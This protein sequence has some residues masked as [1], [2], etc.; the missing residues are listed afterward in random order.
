M[1]DICSLRD[2]THSSPAYHEIYTSERERIF[3]RVTINELKGKGID[4]LTDSMLVDVRSVRK[5]TD[6]VHQTICATFEKLYD[7]HFIT[8][9]KPLILSIEQCH[10]L[11]KLDNVAA[12][13]VSMTSTPQD[14]TII[15]SYK[16]LPSEESAYWTE[17]CYFDVSR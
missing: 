3:T 12:W 1:P 11:R 7:H 5:T 13:N 6:A 10:T 14:N 9:N 2:L 16:K 8:P 17:Q 15:A 4:I